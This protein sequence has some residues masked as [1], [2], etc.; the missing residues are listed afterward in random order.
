MLADVAARPANTFLFGSAYFSV[1]GEFGATWEGPILDDRSLLDEAVRQQRY[2]DVIYHSRRLLQTEAHSDD[3]DAALVD[4]P[5]QQL[6]YTDRISGE[7][8]LNP[9][10]APMDRHAR[11]DLIRAGRLVER[12]IGD[13][14]FRV[15]DAGNTMFVVLS[16]ELGVSFD[17]DPQP[18][19][20]DPAPAIRI[21]VG[22]IVGELAFALHRKRTAT[23]QCLAR[24]SLLSLNPQAVEA[25]ARGSRSPR[26]LRVELDQFIRARVLEHLCHNADYL[27]GRR[28]AGPL[29]GIEEPWLWLTGH[30]ELLRHPAKS[31]ISPANGEMREAGLYVLVS[32]ELKGSAPGPRILDGTKLPI[33]HA[34]FPG[35]RLPALRSYDVGADAVI[36]WIGPGGFAGSHIPRNTG[37][38]VID[39]IG[40]A[41]ADQETRLIGA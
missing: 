15:G 16:G 37:R 5:G 26:A 3:A 35:I 25:A 23:L 14:L 22:E 24:T 12:E 9:L 31:S 36:L 19:E 28:G 40:A 41:L 17:R 13:I 21:G 4:I 27:I 38:E 34:D 33:V 30:S 6:T 20:G 18:I 39:A 7:S 11:A 10:L 32:G 1:G 8:K 2:W 29:R